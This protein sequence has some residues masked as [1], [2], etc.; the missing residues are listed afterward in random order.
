MNINFNNIG[1]RSAAFGIGDQVT[2]ESQRPEGQKPNGLKLSSTE[3]LQVNDLLGGSEPVAEVPAE[4]LVRDDRLGRLVASAFCL[5]AP[6][7]PDFKA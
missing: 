6:P 2:A 1:I 4:A 3:N 7:M 5:P